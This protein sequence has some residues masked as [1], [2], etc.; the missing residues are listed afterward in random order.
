MTA[1]DERLAIDTAAWPAA[2]VADALTVMARH[3]GLAPEAVTIEEAPALPRDRQEAWIDACA[4]RLHLEAER[5]EI[6]YGDLDAA[7]A[8]ARH[9]LVPIAVADEPA[10]RFLIVVGPGR[11]LTPD[12]RRVRVRTAALR[13]AICRAREADPAVAADA[14]LD[15]VGVAPARRARARTILLAQQLADV[16]IVA[17]R[18]RPAADGPMRALVADA[19]LG[20]PLAALALLH[21]LYLLFWVAAWWL[22]G[23]AVLEGRLDY[24]WL[25]AWG[26]LLITLVPLRVAALRLQGRVA[27]AAGALLKARLLT[28]ALRLDPDAVLADGPGHLLGRVIESEAVESL[29]LGGGF[30]AAV[31]AI[32]IAAAAIV[33]AAGYS[34][35]M[36]LVLIAWCAVAAMIAWRYATRTAAWSTSRLAMTDTLV[37]RMVGHR[38]RLAQEAPA[39]WH[40]RED[41][42]LDLYVAASRG[43]DRAETALLAAIPQGWLV[44]GLLAIGPAFVADGLTT[45]RLAAALGGVLL[46]ARAFHRLA[47]ALWQILDARV[48]WRQIAPIL[49]AVRPVERGAPTFAIA[50]DPSMPSPNAPA[51]VLDAQSLVYRYPGRE[52]AVLRRC[53][54]RIA[55][56]DRVLLEGASGGGKSTLIALLTGLRTPQA[57]LLL[58]GGLDRPTLGADGWR[59]R[60]VAAPQFHQNHVITGPLLFNLLMGRGT[61]TKDDEQEALEICGELGL[62]PLI[63]RMPGGLQQMVGET[64]WQL[65]QG[66]RSRVFMARALLQRADLVVLDESF[67]AL[68]PETL[69]A[70]VSCVIK[71]APALLVVAHR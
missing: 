50:A 40:E 54:L 16:H 31:A 5:L 43:R 6:G 18:L 37:E 3:A 42:E 55:H 20:G 53:H 21:G 36:T 11:L 60:V 29:A 8:S 70:A 46:A 51:V 52:S 44:V 1:A 34:G 12:L 7:L 33:L 27:V 71:R 58:A 62:G 39:R 35:W 48:A 19:R 63:E 38:T 49:A 25:T 22:V 28:G 14:L 10:D 9:L 23:N 2:R 67:A 68:D 66:E 32:E 47:S 4:N 26:L 45:S 65:S 56:G 15:D 24:G 61:F 13:E 17:W 59:R 69:D 41:Q 64:G 57:G 30:A